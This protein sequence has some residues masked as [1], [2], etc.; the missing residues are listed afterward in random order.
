MA[1]H[2]CHPSTQGGE[3]LPSRR[4]PPW[5]NTESPGSDLEAE[6]LLW[7]WLGVGVASSSLWGSRRFW[8]LDIQAQRQFLLGANSGDPPQVDGALTEGPEAVPGWPGLLVCAREATSFVRTHT[9]VCAH[10]C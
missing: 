9:V 4:D 7:V 5:G 10:V 2:A 8:E 1:A 3:E 6:S